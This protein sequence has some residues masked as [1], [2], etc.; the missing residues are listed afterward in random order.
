MIGHFDQLN[1]VLQNLQQAP[2]AQLQ[3]SL[4]SLI[5]TL[6]NLRSSGDVTHSSPTSISFMLHTVPKFSSALASQDI[7][8]LSRLPFF[9]CSAAMSGLFVEKLI[10]I[11][12][13]HV[14]S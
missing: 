6:L 8:R 9:V 13:T 2:L 12:N 7:P 11:P 10:S 3:Q 1:R 14:T 4:P 5:M